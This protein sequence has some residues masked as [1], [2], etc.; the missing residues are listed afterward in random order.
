MSGQ[1]LGGKTD[2]YQGP[3]RNRRAKEV[4]SRTPVWDNKE[5][6]GRW[7]LFIK[8]E[9]ERSNLWMGILCWQRQISLLPSIVIARGFMLNC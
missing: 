5:K 4:H 8:R 9:E 3:K 1:G 6:H 7:V 2:T